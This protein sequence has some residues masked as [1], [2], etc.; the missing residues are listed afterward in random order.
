[1]GTQPQAPY[2][3]LHSVN[4]CQLSVYPYQGSG[5]S[6]AKPPTMLIRLFLL[7]AAV[8]PYALADVEFTSPAAGATLTGGS[9]IKVAWK[10]SGSDP[11]LSDLQGYSLFLCAGGNDASGANAFVSACLQRPELSTCSLGS[12]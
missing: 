12:G 2:I 11:P 1:M 3:I 5:Y 7:L 4:F 8:A 9:T 10:D 6:P